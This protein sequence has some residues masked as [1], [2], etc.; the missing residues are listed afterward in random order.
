MMM[1][2]GDWSALTRLFVI[3]MSSPPSTTGNTTLGSA[4]V[5]GIAST[6]G[7]TADDT[8]YSISG[9]GIQQGARIVSVDSATQIT[10][11]VVATSTE[12]A[13]D[14]TFSQDTYALP[15]DWDMPTNRTQWDR[16]NHWELQGAISPQQYQWLVAGIVATGPR[17]KYRISGTTVVIWPPPSSED[18]PSTLAMEYLS[19]YW[20]LSSTGTP[21]PRFTADTDTTVFDPDIMVMGLKWLFFQV[22]GF[23]YTELRRQWNEQVSVF[24]ASDKGAATLDMSGR[25]WPMFI[26]PA[27]VQD[28]NFPG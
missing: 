27:N 10:M 26:S 14:I 7:I 1:A 23:E 18:T 11:D 5:T 9:T 8:Y 24:A 2:Q 25:S 17:R 3:T 12:T 16:T 28:G 13:T 20:V 22:K 21:K 15:A 4:V 6:A 19:S